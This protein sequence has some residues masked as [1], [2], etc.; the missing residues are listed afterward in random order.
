MKIALIRLAV[1]VIVLALWQQ[2]PDRLTFFLSRPSDIAQSL[3]SLVADGSLFRHMGITAMEAG[4]GFFAGGVLG[5]LVGLLMGRIKILADVVDPILM[6]LY[7]LPKVALAPLFVMWFGIGITMKIVF[8]AVI[9]FFLVFFNTYTGVRHVS[10]E[11]IT[12]LRLMGANEWHLMTK[13]VIPAAFTWIFAGLRLS[14]PYALIGAIVAEIIAANRGL[15]Y[16]V[17]HG[18][19]QFDTAAVFAA[20]IAIIMLAVALNFS[21]KVIERW[22]MP[23]KSAEDQRELVV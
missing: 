1:L 23:W 22:L 12:V 8:T 4:L 9:V 14:V 13:V 16:L 5:T 10:R 18:A 20:L 19:A 15:G 3:W 17:A 6:A 2:V 21:V 7:S 11:Q